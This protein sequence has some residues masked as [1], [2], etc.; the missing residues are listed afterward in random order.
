MAFCSI[1]NFIETENFSISPEWSCFLVDNGSLRAEPTLHLRNVARELGGFLEVPVHPVSLLHSSKVDAGLLGGMSAQLLEPMVRQ[2]LK[3]PEYQ[4]V[5][6]VPQFFGPSRALTD[7]LPER[8]DRLRKERGEVEIRQAD[9]LL[10]LEDDSAETLAE[11][12]KDRVLEVIDTNSKEC[13]LPQVVLVDHGSA[14][15]GVNAVRKA[16]AVHLKEI[17]SDGI[18]DL[19][20]CSMERP[21]GAEVVENP[22]LS[23]VLPHL[24]PD[25]PVLLA[26]M[27]FA[28]GKHAGRGGDVE[29]ICKESGVQNW[30]RTETIGNHPLLIQLLA[31][32][33]WDAV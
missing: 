31:K 29:R 16:V 32:R 11:V 22:L 23:E 14:L 10:N 25:Y 5:L 18:H 13:Q 21:D 8:L 26:M 6:V 12:I 27:F 33:A 3:F 20:D 24:S 2:F 9:C 15:S 19:V 30:F 7:Y 4:N 17:L 28:E 1:K